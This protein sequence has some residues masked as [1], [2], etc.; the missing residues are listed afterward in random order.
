M[1]YKFKSKE[2]ITKKYWKMWLVDWSFYL[3]KV[4]MARP[5]WKTKPINQVRVQQDYNVSCQCGCVCFLF[6]LHCNDWDTCNSLS[7]SFG[8]VCDCDA[9]SSMTMMVMLALLLFSLMLRPVS[10]GSQNSVQEF[11]RYWISSPLLRGNL[12]YVNQCFPFIL[13]MVVIRN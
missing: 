10:M 8:A 7:V 12:R 2:W 6:S 9:C 3:Q 1:N 5:Q 4:P 11:L 13:Q